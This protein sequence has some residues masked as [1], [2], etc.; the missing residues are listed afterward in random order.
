V[1]DATGSYEVDIWGSLRNAAAEGRD[2][3]QASA[4]DLAA[5]RLS[6]QAELASD[7]MALRGLDAQAA[8]L[9]ET[10]DAF[11]KALDLTQTRFA[12]HISSGLDVARAQAQLDTARAQVSDVA[13]RRALLEHAIAALVGKPASDFSLAAGTQDDVPPTPPTG[14]P[15][16]LLE[17]RPDIAAAERQ[18]AAADAGI[19]V[20]RAAFYPALTLTGIGGTQD[21]GLDLLSLPLAF[22][23]FGPNVSLPIFEGGALDA[24]E[25]QAYAQYCEASAD[26]RSAVLDAFREVEDNLA[27]IHW[28]DREGQ[29]E[30]AGTEAAKRALDIALNLYREGVDSYLEVVTAQTTYLDA[31]EAALD[32]QTRQLTADVGLIRALGGGWGTAA[33]PS[34]DATLKLAPNTLDA[35]PPKSQPL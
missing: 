25:A 13:A 20:A 24:K 17:R 6:L 18:V 4:A 12:G 34:D 15:S 21:T 23:T 35:T 33:L 32:I 5:M 19:G 27:L 1:L 11:Q 30:D 22:W 2:F 26:Y 16:T 7:Y 29:D 28:L 9:A 8:F 31:E 10:V 3:A 14:L